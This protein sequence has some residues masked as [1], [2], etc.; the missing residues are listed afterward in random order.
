[1]AY[2]N[3]LPSGNYQTQI[4]LKG[5]EPITKTFPTKK[6]AT[7]FVREVDDDNYPDT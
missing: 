4:R 3:K 6:L 5:L 7:K 2:I 1:M